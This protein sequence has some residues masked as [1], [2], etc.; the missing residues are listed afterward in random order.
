M[1]KIENLSTR[2]GDVQIAQELDPLT[3]EELEQQGL[4]ILYF[5]YASQSIEQAP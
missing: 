2:Y 5:Q 4:E 3:R 1:L